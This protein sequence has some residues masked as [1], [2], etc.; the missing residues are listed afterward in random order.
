ML[1]IGVLLESANCNLLLANC[2]K[3]LQD[4][5]SK[6][7]DANQN[8]V[9]VR[10]KQG[11]GTYGKSFSLAVITELSP[12]QYHEKTIAK[13]E[14]NFFSKISRTHHM[15]SHNHFTVYDFCLLEDL[16]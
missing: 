7:I 9:R 4:R 13:V 1:K 16:K 10:Q 8:Y 5:S 12:T 3:S 14:P 6:L 15:H 2:I 11:F